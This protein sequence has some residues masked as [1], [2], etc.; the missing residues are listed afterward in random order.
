[1]FVAR[2]ILCFCFVSNEYSRPN[3][4]SGVYAVGG[5]GVH[6]D[7]FAQKIQEEKEEYRIE[8]ENDNG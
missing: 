7:I 2:N 1:M 8:H 6:N 4:V 5:G 3:V